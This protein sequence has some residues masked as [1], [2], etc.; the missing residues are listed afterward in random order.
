MDRDEHRCMIT[1]ALSESE[2]VKQGAIEG[3]LWGNLE[4]HHI[5]HF[6]LAGFDKEVP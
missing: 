6:S 4:V 1:R 3:R 5:I 2:W